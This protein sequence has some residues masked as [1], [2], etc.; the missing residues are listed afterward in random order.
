[1]RSDQETLGTDLNHLFTQTMQGCS[2]EYQLLHDTEDKPVE[3]YV[4]KEDKYQVFRLNLKT[5]VLTTNTEN[6]FLGMYK[7]RVKVIAS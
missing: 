6:V 5:G 4:E 1:M 3:F 7:F 2:V